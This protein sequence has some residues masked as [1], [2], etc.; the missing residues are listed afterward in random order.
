M[1]RVAVVRLEQTEG[2][3]DRH[4]GRPRQDERSERKRRRPPEERDEHITLGADRAVALERHHLAAPERG[5]QLDA[6]ADRAADDEPH[7]V[8]VAPHPALEPRDRL[9]RHDDVRARRV[10]PASS[11]PAISQLPTWA[12][13]DT[14]PAASPRTWLSLTRP[15]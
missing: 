15:T 8:T 2:R 5:D 6:D 1:N 10:R 3:H 12:V 13:T 4:A 9:R 7:A 11:R 14:T